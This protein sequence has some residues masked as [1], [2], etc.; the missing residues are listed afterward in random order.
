MTPL[1]NIN[2]RHGVL[3][4]RSEVKA[5]DQTE[6]N[7]TWVHKYSMDFKQNICEG[8]AVLTDARTLLQLTLNSGFCDKPTT[9]RYSIED[10]IYEG[11]NCF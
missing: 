5:K 8:R 10:C 3:C 9:L 4:G 7:D 11:R 6:T 2:G 1:L